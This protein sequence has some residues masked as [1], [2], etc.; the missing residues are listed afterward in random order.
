M[1]AQE[2]YTTRTVSEYTLTFDNAG[3]IGELKHYLQEAV[4]YIE[5]IT[6]NKRPISKDIKNL[7][8][9]LITAQKNLLP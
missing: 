8:K 3:D 1:S 9:Q 7:I 6:I 4:Y 2:E 5:H